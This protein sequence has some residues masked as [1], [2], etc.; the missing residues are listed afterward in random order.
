MSMILSWVLF[1][2]VL[3]A[4]GLGWGALLGW[5]AGERDLGAL[6]IPVG[7]AAAIVVAALL[8]A[9][10]GTAPAAAPV[11]AAGALAGLARAW[12]RATLP[13]QAIL[14][15]IGVIAIYGAPVIFS[16][17]DTFLGYI[18][19]DDTAQWLGF[20]DQFFSH[21]RSLASLSTSSTYWIVLNAN[22]TVSGYPSGGFM[23]PGIGHWITGIDVA[24]IFQPTIAVCAGAL[25]LCCY[26][27]ITPVLES[28]WLRAFVCFIA[29]QSA[30][31]FGYAAWG[32][33][34]ELTIAFLLA[35]VMAV[36]A[37]LLARELREES[38]LASARATIP[39]AVSAAALIVTIG[40]GAGVYL[41][42]AA[43]AVLVALLVRGRRGLLQLGG[44][45]AA[46]PLTAAL[47]VPTWL[48]LNK[49]VAA[50]KGFV[51]SASAPPS[52]ETLFGN[53]ISPLRAIQVAGVWLDGDFRSFP[54]PPPGLINHILVYVV[55][56]AALFGIAW[57]AWRR[58]FGP[59]LYVAIALA[60]LAFL[61]YKG[62]VPWIMGKS[63]AFS[64]PAVLLVGMTGAAVLF[65][66][67]NRFALAAGIVALGA[68]T[69]GVIWSNYLQYHNV[70]L[71]PRARLSELQ[72]IAPLAAREPPTFINEYEIY[73]DRHFLRAGQPIEP[74]EYRPEDLPTTN[75][76]L[77]T[78]SAWADIDAFGLPT[79]APYRSLVVRVAPTLS[80][81]PSIYGR[82][83]VWSGR[84]YQLWQQPLHPSERVLEHV[85]L[86]DTTTYLYCGNAEAPATPLSDCSIQPAAVPLCRQVRTLAATASREHAE[87]LAFERTN[88][89]V[90]RATQTV[91]APPQWYIFG[92]NLSP[93]ATGA[94]AT[95]TITLTHAVHGYR[96]WLGGG[97]QRGF[98]VSVDGHGIGSISDAL[99]PP[100]AYEQVG[101]ALD[102]PAGKHTITA[103]FPSE[104]L[105]P[106]S[107][108]TEATY[109]ELFAIAL[110][111]PI[112]QGSYVQTTP[113][114]AAAT[115]CGHTLDWLEIVAPQ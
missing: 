87:L 33:I 12:R 68:I 86:G 5:A 15:A 1:P 28:R 59:I 94:S 37:R 69:G 95:A 38:L 103:T 18:R 90:V 10:E 36:A 4:V 97:F 110:A 61:S 53:L 2:L 105:G 98:D 34:K 32:G 6:A 14:A 40:V 7:L 107:A 109:T 78:D 88:P 64:S 13:P 47:M 70:S 23:L 39:L 67:D 91:Y 71:A 89:Y 35:L 82:A 72:A 26:D 99:D 51:P 46:L 50:T 85:P 43:L 44:Y 112:G 100:G 27:L 24:W 11:V 104:G 55:F 9:F 8:T 76:A 96:V 57:M 102:L 20:M 115:L 66:R 93:A 73:A 108:D 41:V 48:L 92:P 62:T 17:Q 16:G 31:L 79:L 60:V 114:R 54:N 29:A 63:L 3:G 113:A 25:S 58:S 75:N 80:R 45:L 81:P 56:A 42:P 52:H 19:L 74:A 101:P 30:L 84:Y 22:L 111:P 83:P 77:L 21:G 106:G 65:S 49:S